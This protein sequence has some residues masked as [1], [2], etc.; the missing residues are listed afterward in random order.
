MAALFGAIAGPVSDLINGA[1]NRA[2]EKEMMNMQA[3]M[4]SQHSTR[5][6]C[7]LWRRVGAVSWPLVTVWAQ[8]AMY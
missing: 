5:V 2:H 8:N 6:L 7:S 4:V 3:K 1:A